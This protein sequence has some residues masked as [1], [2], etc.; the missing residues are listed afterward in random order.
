MKLFKIISIFLAVSILM[1]FIGSA[2]VLASTA[3]GFTADE[4]K[5]EI[6]NMQ[7]SGIADDNVNNSMKSLGATII[8]ILTLVG[9]FI[10]VIL[11]V[12]FGIKWMT[13]NPNKK[14]ELKEDAWN[15]IIG[16]GLLFGAGPIAQWIYNIV[17]KI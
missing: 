13:A 15:Y 1:V 5:N 4:L 8:R 9:T 3:A 10:G 17:T 14:S 16:A 7:T 6:G 11:L 2:G 12:I